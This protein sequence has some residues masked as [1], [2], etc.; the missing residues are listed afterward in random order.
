MYCS[1]FKREN[2]AKNVEIMSGFTCSE[3]LKLEICLKDLI[4][5]SW[6]AI[7]VKP[8]PMTEISLLIDT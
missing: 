1:V 5:H 7:T 8:A 2:M 4:L 3:G 6:N